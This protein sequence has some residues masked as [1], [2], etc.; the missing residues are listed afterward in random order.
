MMELRHTPLLPE[1]CSDTT[2]SCV[3]MAKRTPNY[4]SALGGCQL[5]GRNRGRTQRKKEQMDD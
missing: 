1:A 2:V 3:M 4:H 5:V